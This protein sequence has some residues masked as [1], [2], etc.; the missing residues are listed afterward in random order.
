MTPPAYSSH[1]LWPAPI[2][3]YTPSSRTKPDI[4]TLQFCVCP[5]K[6]PAAPPRI[7]I[8]VCF[9]ILYFEVITASTALPISPPTLIV[10]VVL[11]LCTSLPSSSLA[12]TKSAVV[13]KVLPAVITPTMPPAAPVFSLLVPTLFATFTALETLTVTPSPILPATPPAISDQSSR[14]EISTPLPSI[15]NSAS[16]GPT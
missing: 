4:V 2:P 16:A 8:S 14:E 9:V 15:R 12:I 5:T 6:P 3:A 11:V 10:S 1:V 7:L 13:R